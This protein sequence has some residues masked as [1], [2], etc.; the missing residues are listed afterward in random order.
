MSEAS[1]IKPA[2][3][4]N[5]R[6]AS[7][8]QDE[9]QVQVQKAAAPGRGLRGL[10]KPQPQVRSLEPWLWLTHATHVQA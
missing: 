8:I 4:T 3:L 2:R 7:W 5:E 10:A 1:T 9:I 6:E